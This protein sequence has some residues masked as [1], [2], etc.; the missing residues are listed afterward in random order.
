MQ[1][2]KA[3][4]L[5]WCYGDLLDNA[6]RGKVAEF[7]VAKACC[8]AK[9]YRQEWDSTDLYV[10]DI[11]VEIKSSAYLQ[12]W[13]QDKPSEVK[14]DIAPRMQ[15]WDSNTNSWEVFSTPQRVAKV[16]VF[17]VFKELDRQIADPLNVGQW[18][19]YVVATKMLN[20]K[21]PNQKTISLNPLRR[22]TEMAEYEN[23]K[24]AIENSVKE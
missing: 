12:T 20:E 5:E 22:L 19:F 2:D 18:D 9:G 21:F 11:P 14:F 6:N 4:C 17:C 13:H 7:V 8:V 15:A 24:L 23:L 3:E 16:Y 1:L 10:G